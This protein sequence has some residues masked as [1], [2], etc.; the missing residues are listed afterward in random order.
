MSEY[1][2]F[3]LTAI[4]RKDLS[5]PMRHLLDKNLLQGKILD[6]GCG[7]GDDLDKLLGLGLDIVG[8]DK[9][10]PKY[11]DDE[12]LKFKYDTVTCH[13]VCNVIP[14]LPTHQNVIQTIRDLGKNTYVSVRADTKSIKDSWKWDDHAQ[15]YQTS[16]GSWQRFYD[17]GMINLLFGDVEYLLNN[18]SVKLFKLK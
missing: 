13:Y 9:Y 1:N 12:L 16:T 15:A 10:N 2:P 17:T 18:S 11:Y 5:V 6:F 3:K 14:D 8:Y 4:K 7:R